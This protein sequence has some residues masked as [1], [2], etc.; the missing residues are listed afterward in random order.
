MSSVTGDLD[1]KCA[2]CGSSGAADNGLCLRCTTRVIQGQPM[3]SA[4]GQAV[5]DNFAA[6]QQRYRDRS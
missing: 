6:Q 4:P 2:E 1:R 5:A 3:R